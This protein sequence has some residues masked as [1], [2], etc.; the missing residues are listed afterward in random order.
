ME[1]IS[2]FED[3]K[4]AFPKSHDDIVKLH[5]EYIAEGETDSDA[6]TWSD[7]KNG[8]SYYFYGKKVF[9]LT[10][11]SSGKAK[12][13]IQQDN[14]KPITLTAD[15]PDLLDH[16]K[17]LKEKKKEIF[18]NLITDTFG[19]CNDFERCSD[20][21]QCLHPEKRFYNGCMYRRN[22]EAGKVFYG[23]NRNA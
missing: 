21:L 3:E 6:F 15:S 13:S 2:L 20:A 22:L 4:I 8:R 11:T 17:V 19:C 7:I 5:T 14:E 23:K 9:E 12:L 10:T 18:R 16:I 1:Q